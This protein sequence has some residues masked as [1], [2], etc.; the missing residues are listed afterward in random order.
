MNSK[1]I[2]KITTP[3]EQWVKEDDKRGA[4]VIVFEESVEKDKTGVQTCEF[5]FG[6]DSGMLARAISLRAD[7][8]NSVLCPLVNLKMNEFFQKQ[9][10]KRRRENG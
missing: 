7:S 1:E 3:I 4:L 9:L 10:G 2:T 6:E 8:P 5:L